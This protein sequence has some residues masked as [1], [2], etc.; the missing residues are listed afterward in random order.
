MRSA[1][2]AIRVWPVPLLAL[3]DWSSRSRFRVKSGEMEERRQAFSRCQPVVSVRSLFA[4][5]L[6]PLRGAIALQYRQR[7]IADR[8]VHDA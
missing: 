1:V 7:G 5:I 2:S 6:K 3:A 4:L 8:R